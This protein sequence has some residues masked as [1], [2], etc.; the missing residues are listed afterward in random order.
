MNFQGILYRVLP[1]SIVLALTACSRLHEPQATNSNPAATER[2]NQKVVRKITPADLRFDRSSSTA[3]ISSAQKFIIP[4]SQLG[5]SG[6]PLVYPKG[7][8]KVGLPILTTKA[9][10]SDKEG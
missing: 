5:P 6:E 9:N 2:E 4:V 7:H 3:V 1:L 8:E 10:Q